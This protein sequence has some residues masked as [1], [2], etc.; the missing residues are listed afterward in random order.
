M[1]KYLL[2]II[3][4]L[5][6]SFY[7]NAQVF[8]ND[9]SVVIIESNA[10]LSSEGKV[11]NTQSG[12][13]E[14]EGTLSAAT[15]LENNLSSILK[16]DGHYLVGEDWINSATFTAGNST[17]TFNGDNN[18]DLTSSGDA[19][20]HLRMDKG[21]G[22]LIN[23]QDALSMNGN[24]SF[25]QPN[26]F[27]VLNGF[28]FTLASATS[29]TG[30][31]ADNFFVTNASGILRQES[32]TTFTF[33]VGFNTTSYNPLSLTQS[34]T[35]DRIGVR[36]LENVLADGST[37]SPLT[38]VVDASWE[39]S[40]QTAGGSTLS[41]TAQWAASDELGT[42]DR[43][44]C[45][46]AYHDGTCWDLTQALQGV[47]GGA[48]PY[49]ISRSTISSLGIFAVGGNPLLKPLRVAPKLLLE[50]PYSSGGEMHDLLRQAG[51]IP[52]TEPFTALGYTHVEP[53]GGETIAPAILT[54]TGSN[55]IVDWVFVEIRTG[56]GSGTTVAT[57]SALLQKDGDIVDL[58]GSSALNFGGVANGAYYVLIR[59]RNHIGVMS[60]STLALTKTAASLDFTTSTAN[61]LGG[62][63]S[64]TDLGDGFFAIFSGDYNGNGQIQNTDANSLILDIGTSGYKAGDLDL[65][66]EVQNSELQTILIPNIG[67]GTQ[68]DY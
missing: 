20:H 46:I 34:G 60:I 64:L 56:T 66:G 29:I 26:N 36:S 9:G 43:S 55:A 15:S 39:V 8:Y 44:D 52:T 11:V 53:G 5:F 32:M 38:D 54:T 61:A 10:V 57:R 49:T 7:S 62:A 24:F 17:V 35:P 19:F 3:A 27:A 47:A 12:V 23:L 67:K 45:G 50:G 40:E 6:L 59:S 22:G 18:S 28:S 13:I 1:K 58:D 2:S 48:D 51:H 33:P 31:D 37:G 14:T 63:L 4:L 65:N 30:A 21:T 41:M 42:F 68:F 16:G 25:L